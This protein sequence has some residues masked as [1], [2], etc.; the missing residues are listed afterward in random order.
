MHTY[1]NICPLT[2]VKGILKVHISGPLTLTIKVIG[3]LIYSG[4]IYWRYILAP[5]QFPCLRG[6]VEARSQFNTCST[7]LVI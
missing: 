3:R 6:I 1:H 7:R 2:K 4:A 5:S